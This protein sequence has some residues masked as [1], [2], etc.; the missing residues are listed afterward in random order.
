M[1]VVDCAILSVSVYELS[2]SGVST[3]GNISTSGPKFVVAVVLSN[4]DLVQMN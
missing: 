1:N 3:N 4:V 2:V